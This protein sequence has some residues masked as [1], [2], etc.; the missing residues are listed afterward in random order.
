MKTKFFCWGV[1]AL[2]GVFFAAPAQALEP[3]ESA[4]L[5]EFRTMTRQYPDDVREALELYLHYHSSFALTTAS[6]T[7]SSI[8]FFGRTLADVEVEQQQSG[9]FNTP[10]DQARR[11]IT[12]T[13]A[14]KYICPQLAQR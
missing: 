4:F 2:L 12:N 11:H 1:V 13:L 10:V 14:V 8:S 7:C 5:S 3:H 6:N 9:T